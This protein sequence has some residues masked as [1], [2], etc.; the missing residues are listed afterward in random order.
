V[1]PRNALVNLIGHLAPLLA[2]LFL[3]PPL[4]TRLDADRFGFLTLAWVLIGYFSVFD[5]GFARALSRLIAERR[6]TAPPSW[7]RQLSGSALSLT[8]GLG[9]LAGSLL[10]VLSDFLC[11][12]V[13][14]I[15]PHLQGEATGALRILASCVPFVTLTSV[16]R[17]LLEAGYRFGWV[18]ALRIPTGV[19]LFAAPLIALFWSADLI[20]LALS[21]ALVRGLS[22]LAH[23]A[24][25][26]RLY[27]TLTALDRPRGFAV[28]EMLGFGVWVTV[29]NIVG[30][31]LLYI[32][33]FM[34]GALATVSAVAFYAMPYEVVVRLWIIPAALAGVMFPVMAAA[35]DDHLARLYRIGMKTVLVAV[36]PLAL[37]IVAFAPE[38][39]DLLLGPDYSRNGTRV[40]QLLS[41]GVAI[42]CVAYVPATI[43]QARGRADLMAKMHV[44]ELPLF[45]VLLALLIPYWGVEGAAL[46]T[47]LRCTADAAIVFVMA[48]KT[49]PDAQPRLKRQ[50]I[51]AMVLAVVF[52]AGAM[53]PFSLSE[54]ILYFLAAL[55]AF[56]ALGWYVLLDATERSRARHPLDL[57]TGEQRS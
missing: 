34:I 7:L 44:A 27:P 50:Q 11:T 6:S 36:F 35:R 38:W 28:R 13:L 22:L 32:D 26:A 45:L 37:A 48:G 15:P 8:L 57:I 14:R 33:R 56:A 55:F 42:N 20:T 49:A 19:L 24:V 29:S 12:Y 54:R 46:A 53:A 10:F 2:A 47:A 41:I 39:R 4:V 17:G 1:I 43:I 9:L 51:G 3:V 18:N 40:A 16:L 5:L 21:L 31:L 30:P 52:L 23:W 25:C